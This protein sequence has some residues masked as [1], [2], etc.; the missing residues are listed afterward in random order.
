MKTYELIGVL[1][2]IIFWWLIYSFE[3]KFF[4]S[5]LKKKASPRSK[6]RISIHVLAV[7]GI[8]CLIYGYFVEPYWTD[9]R[10]VEIRTD[11]LK[12]TDF[13]IVQI[14]DLHCDERVRNEKKL[15][16]IINALNPDVVVF[17]GDALNSINALS[18]FKETMSDMKAKIGKYAVRGNF[19]VWFWRK[20]DLFSTTGFVELDGQSVT[21]SKNS[22]IF[23]IS[24][25]SVDNS[26]RNLSFLKSLPPEAYNILLFHYPGIN[27]EIGESQVDLFLSGHTHGGQIAVPFYGALVTLSKYGKKYESG[28]YD[29]DRKILYVNR[30]IG[31]EGGSAP[32]VRFLSR[33]EI[34]VFHIKP[35]IDTSEQSHVHSSK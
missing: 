3:I 17:T 30:G 14:S 2:F 29:I 21:L 24:G 23:S 1:I 15:P 26:L 20:V 31:M 12:K 33:P 32:R 28:R 16:A 25:L 7:F 27:E 4:V 9:V 5:C 13:T 18:T 8:G 6:F 22:E 34:T 19:D 35:K 10:H 11:K